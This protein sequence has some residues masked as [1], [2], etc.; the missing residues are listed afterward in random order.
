MLIFV[1]NQVQEELIMR[2]LLLENLFTHL[3]ATVPVK[4]TEQAGQW[5]F[6]SSIQIHLDGL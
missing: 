5:M 4:T 3:E 6:M 2:R 1:I